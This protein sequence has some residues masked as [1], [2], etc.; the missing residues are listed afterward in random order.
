MARHK[1]T[2]GVVIFHLKKLWPFDPDDRPNSEQPCARCGH[3]FRFHILHDHPVLCGVSG[4]R[5]REFM[6]NPYE[7]IKAGRKTSE[8]RDMIY[9]WVKRLCENADWK[10]DVGPQDLTK[11]LRVHKAW[12]VS[13]YPKGSPPFPRLEADITGL[14]CDS[15][16][17][18]LE[19]KF[20]NVVEKVG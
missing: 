5:C 13:G 20:T 7:E 3:A 15:L 18:Q 10:V 1:T 6:V 9:Y 14:F 11:L 4:C 17:M 12:F 8:F 19:I 16:V 2:I